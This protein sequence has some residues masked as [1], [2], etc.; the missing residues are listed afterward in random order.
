MS[1]FETHR[2]TQHGRH[3]LNATERISMR[4]LYAKVVRYA[5]ACSLFRCLDVAAPKYSGLMWL[6]FRYRTL[7][8]KIIGSTSKHSEPD[9]NI[10]FAPG[11][12]SKQAKP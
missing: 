6:R 5:L 2:H 9:L 7:R 1:E 11:R 4:T 8:R 10:R 12:K 3:P